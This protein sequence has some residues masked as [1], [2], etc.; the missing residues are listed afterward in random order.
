[1]R[2]GSAAGDAALP[3]LMVLL[4]ATLHRSL[5]SP[6]HTL[7]G[8]LSRPAAGLQRAGAEPQRRQGAAAV[9][10]RS[11]AERGARRPAG[12]VQLAGGAGG[13]GCSGVRHRHNRLPI[14]AVRCCLSSQ[15]T[16]CF[17]WPVATCAEGAAGGWRA[18]TRLQCVSCTSAAGCSYTRHIAATTPVLPPCPEVTVARLRT[19]AAGKG[20]HTS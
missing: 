2:V 17:G 10:G 8:P 18:A 12:A 7:A 6:L 16:G 3:A 19:M 4:A 9:W 14:Q 11:R 15:S 13:R 1:M 20:L 5:S